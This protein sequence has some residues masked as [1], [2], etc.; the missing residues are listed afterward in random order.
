MKFVSLIL[1]NMVRSKVRS[2]LT[3]VAIMISVFIFASLLSLDHGVQRMVQATGG[4]QVL[5][6]FEKYKACPPYSRLPVHYA[7]QI[8]QL[9]HVTAVM[10]VRFL[11]SFCGTTTDLVSIHG[12]EPDRLRRFRE[13]ELPDAHY[14]AFA[15][16][17]G[18]AIVGSNIAA[19]YGW[20]IGQQVTLPQLRGI[21]FTVR[22]I[23]NAPGSSLEEVVLVDR[24]YLE[25]SIN[26]I[27]VTTMFLVEVDDPAQ[28]GATGA[29]IDGMTANYD[30]QTKS[31][32]E[33]G[34]ISDQISGFKE[35]VH[36]SQLVAYA[37]LLM[38]LAAVA[39]SVSMS[40]RE[41]LRETA[42]M[43]LL[44]FDRRLVARLILVETA[45]LGLT[46]ALVGVGCAWLVVT[47]GHVS[48]SVEGFTLYP[49]LTWRIA[50]GAVAVGLILTTVAT[51]LPALS[52]ARRP[53]IDAL[54]G[55]D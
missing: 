12:I 42:V 19:K 34:F 26:E 15:G 17:R 44:G 35:L 45:L 31:G 51:Y 47:L 4:D 37:A 29:I 33:R 40:V 28:L 55:V 1:K 49:T 24:E 41:R 2:L 46:A 21:G 38:L 25:T 27:G 36:F 30:K 53:I 7:D 5:I 14:E 43:K 22:G 9:P 54:R 3:F 32:P 18:A 13:L 50:T 39:N 10:P 11:L 23:Y 52:N 8:E 6:V 16:E 20:Q 48:I